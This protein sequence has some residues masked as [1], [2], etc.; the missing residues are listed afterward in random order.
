MKLIL[1][2]GGSGKR[3]WPL[4]NYS[5]SKQFLKVLP[6][7]DGQLE[8]M[9]QRVWSQLE[10]ANLAARASIATGKDQADLIHIQLGSSVP[11]IVEPER[12]DTFAAIAL[13][14]SWLYSVQGA[15]PAE[16]VVILPVD[17][18]VEDPFFERLKLLEDVLDESG[19]E[20]ALMGV[21]PTHPAEKYGYLVPGGPAR[22]E[23]G[24]FTVSRFVEKPSAEAAA[25]LIRQGALWNCGVFAF[26]LGFMLRQLEERALPFRY[27]ELVRQYRRLPKVSFDYEVAEKT[28]RIAALRYDGYWKDLG[29]WNTLTDEIRTPVIGKGVVSDDCVNVHVVN[30]LHIPVVVL[31]LSNVVVSASHDGILVADKAASPRL[32]DLV[33]RVDE[34][35][36]AEECRWGSYRT[37]D[38]QEYPDG[39]EV[40][41]KRVVIHRGQHLSCHWHS[42]R[43]E[44]WTILSGEGEMVT[45][46][47][48]TR[49]RAGET[50][51]IPPRTR[52]AIRALS[53]LEMVEVQIGSGLTEEDV[54]SVAEDWEDIVGLTIADKG[55]GY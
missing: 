52:H 5:R 11:V 27:D 4:S 54:H 18:F 19:A 1:L 22:G 17:P 12:R 28:S 8:S 31:G 24:Y 21:R 2:S 35:P 41:T 7:A 15:D 45:D 3:L 38:F 34:R 16:T 37:L 14:A 44:V 46:G 13:S 30:E 48:M 33:D 53:E 39:R 32:K 47:R 6:R 25:E 23:T 55:G 20:I 40:L 43:T 42:N 50:Y 49:V 26:R 51:R 36:M 9:V 29:T 10:R